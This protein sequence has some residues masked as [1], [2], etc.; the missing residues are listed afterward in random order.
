VLRNL[1]RKVFVAGGFE[2]LKDGQ[3]EQD[4]IRRTR[5]PV[6]EFTAAVT[7]SLR[8]TD[9]DSAMQNGGGRAEDA[10]EKDEV[11]CFL[12]NMIYKVRIPFVLPTATLLYGSLAF[13]D[14]G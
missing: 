2:P 11:E 9:S 8:R 1:F 10:I 13:L 12:A 14:E 4:R 5:I 7:L 6:E 3:T